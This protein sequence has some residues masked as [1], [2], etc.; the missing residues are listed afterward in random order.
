LNKSTR[1]FRAGSNLK[2]KVSSVQEKDRL[3]GGERSKAWQREFPR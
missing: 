3:G 1:R 2:S